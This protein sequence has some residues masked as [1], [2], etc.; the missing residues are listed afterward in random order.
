[1]KKRLLLILLIV[2]GVFITCVTVKSTTREQTE[3]QHTTETQYTTPT[4][5]PYLT[6]GSYNV[7]ILGNY[8]PKYKD[9]KGKHSYDPIPQRIKNN[10][11]VLS[12][13]H[14]DI[15]VL[16]E[17]EVGKPGEW[18]LKDLSYELNK[19]YGKKYKWML[20]DA[21][22]RGFGMVEAIGFLYDS[23]KVTTSGNI[24]II[25][26]NGSRDFAASDFMA[27]DFDFTLIGCHLAWSNPNK[28]KT[29]YQKINDI[30]H[31]PLH[32]SKDP[33][34]IVLGD[35]NRFGKNQQSVKEIRFD[36]TIMFSP[37]VEFWDKNFHSLKQVKKIHIANRGIPQDDPQLL[38][39][40][41]SDNTMVYDKM[42]CTI[43]VME[44][45]GKPM[46]QLI[47]GEDFG[48]IAFDHKSYPN[49]LPE[50]DVQNIKLGWSDHRPIWM[51]FSTN[52]G[53]RDDTTN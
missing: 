20:S 28:R 5:D 23:T 33:D 1:M 18:A 16:E 35:F 7:Y 50:S 51:R 14:L 22:G 38:S 3:N 42:M 15:I 43:D 30:L 36:S 9:S 34:V 13:K 8:D 48:V 2:V 6:I 49:Y 12:L 31:H 27:G 47:Y 37:H 11:K 53:T 46:H 25:K 10:A 4:E 32:Y 44:E 17:V 39:T 19:S 26:S 52:K 41:V 45:F 24:E 29:E 40:T 21:I